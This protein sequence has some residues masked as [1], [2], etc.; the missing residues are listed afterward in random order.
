MSN[1]LDKLRVQLAQHGLDAMLISQ[2]ENRRYLSGFTGSSGLLLISQDRAILATDFRYVKQSQDE[3]PAFELFRIQGD[4][5]R[6]LPALLEG[7]DVYK[8]GFEGKEVPYCTYNDLV[9][10]VRGMDREISL[11]PTENLVESLRAVKDAEELQLIEKAAALSD[12]ALEAVLPQVQPGTSEREL[13]WKLERFMRQNGSEP[14]PFDIIVASGPN[15]ALPHAKPTDRPISQ[16]EPV[17][18]DLGATVGG[19]SSDISR[20]FYMGAGDNTFH[21]IYDI[22]LGAQ[23]TAMATL[24]AGMNGEQA[25]Q[26][27]RTVIEQAGYEENFGHGLGHGI[28]LAAH[29]EPRLG[30]N[31]SDV[32]TDG[33]VFTIEPGIYID[34]WG[35]VRI[36][37]TVVLEEGKVRPLTKARKTGGN[38]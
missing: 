38:R 18:I 2:G 36:E 5:S 32:L 8:L 1:R 9:A 19:Y 17:V 21:R 34:G 6:W 11:I 28:G 22:V 23:L 27:A 25:D 4:L 15:S 7:M 13:A 3:A 14:L 29:E 31:S 24:Q 33:M 37:D 30:P 26:L 10:A 20:T 35:G 12:A 16:N